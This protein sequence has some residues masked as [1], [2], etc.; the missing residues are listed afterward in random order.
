MNRYHCQNDAPH[1]YSDHEKLLKLLI[2]RTRDERLKWMPTSG[3]HRTNVDGIC[4][5]LENHHDQRDG[6]YLT[7]TVGAGKDAVEVK[8]A[9]AD[10]KT[11]Y[12]V[13]TESPAQNLVKKVINSLSN[14]P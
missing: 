11:L 9:H 6:D 3:R 13:I 5:I 14:A 2:L 1:R 12:R 8:A 7:L 4:V 10:M